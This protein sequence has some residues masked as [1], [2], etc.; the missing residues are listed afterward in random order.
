MDFDI[1]ISK[2]S[3]GMFIAE[4]PT[5]IGCV[6]KGRTEQEAEQNILKVIKECMERRV[7]GPCC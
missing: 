1:T 2:D 7:Q 5:I 4:C 6:T 3:E